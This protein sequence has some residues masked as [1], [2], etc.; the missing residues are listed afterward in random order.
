MFKKSID[1]NK[2]R[3]FNI[4]RVYT[5]SNIIKIHDQYFNLTIN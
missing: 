1:K 5:N 3:N 2:L 4:V